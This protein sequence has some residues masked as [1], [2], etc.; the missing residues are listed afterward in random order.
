MGK[1]GPQEPR[2]HT[3]AA[4]ALWKRQHRD[5]WCDTGAAE[6]TQNSA[7]EQKKVWLDDTV[8]TQ[9][10]LSSC[11]CVWCWEHPGKAVTRRL[12][13]DTISVRTAAQ[14]PHSA[15]RNRIPLARLVPGTQSLLNKHTVGLETAKPQLCNSC[16]QSLKRH[17]PTA[18]TPHLLKADRAGERAKEDSSQQDSGVLQEHLYSSKPT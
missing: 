1:K 5:P 10:P 15:W 13:L 7:K 6:A 8:R 9:N 2:R 18:W 11:V 12:G 17:S 16:E 3:V 14:L 4:C